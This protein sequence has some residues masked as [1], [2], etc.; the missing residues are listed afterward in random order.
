MQHVVDVPWRYGR[1]PSAE[2]QL[3]RPGEII[4]HS[5]FSNPGLIWKKRGTKIAWPRY[6]LCRLR[7]RIPGAWT[8][9]TYSPLCISVTWV[10]E[11]V[12]FGKRQ[13]TLTRINEKD[14]VH[15]CFIIP[16]GLLLCCAHRRETVSFAIHLWTVAR[17][18]ME[19]TYG[20]HGRMSPVIKVELGFEVHHAVWMIY[21]CR[22]EENKL[23]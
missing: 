23:F 18:H 1:P 19:F 2:S 12:E 9:C 13:E 6:A 14:G 15:C 11:G 16:H 7:A 22:E 3:D 10:E 4:P 21:S 17:V 8:P 20:F 5:A